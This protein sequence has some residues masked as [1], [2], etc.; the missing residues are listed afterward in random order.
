M[1]PQPI[2][3]PRLSRPNSTE[4]VCDG[5]FYDYDIDDGS[6]EVADLE[7]FPVLH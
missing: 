2:R 6:T 4:G 5:Y 3:P 7:Q 1:N